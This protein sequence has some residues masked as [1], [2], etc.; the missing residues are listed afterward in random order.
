MQILTSFLISATPNYPENNLLFMHQKVGFKLLLTRV[1][2]FVCFDKTNFCKMGQIHGSK[3]I[4][5][6]KNFLF[7]ILSFCLTANTPIKGM[8]KKFYI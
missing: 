2:I 5:C 6:L 8:G 4:C 3:V 7:S 1:I